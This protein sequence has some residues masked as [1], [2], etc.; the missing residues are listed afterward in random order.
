MFKSSNLLLAVTL[1]IGILSILI[2]KSLAHPGPT[3]E[4]GCHYE[5]N[6]QW[7]CHTDVI[8]QTNVDGSKSCY[9]P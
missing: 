7:H 8:C 5:N 9:A 4:N 6:G 2:N 3:D 1:I